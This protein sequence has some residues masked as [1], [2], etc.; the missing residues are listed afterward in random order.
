MKTKLTLILAAMAALTGVATAAPETTVP[1]A[2]SVGR[3]NCDLMA[4]NTVRAVFH[5]IQQA[6]PQGTVQVAVFEVVQNLAHKRV[7]RYGDGQM[8]AG[9]I[10]TVTMDRYLPGQPSSVVDEIMQMQPG[11]EAVMKIDH[12]F[13]FEEPQG[14]NIRPCTRLARKP[15][16]APVPGSVPSVLPQQ[17]GVPQQV[18]P[19]VP[20]VPGNA[21]TPVIPATPTTPATPATP[22]TPGVP[23]P[24]MPAVPEGNMGSGFLYGT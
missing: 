19:A 1:A 7:V 13:L 10:F 6:D 5:G 20:T 24:V 18:I 16:T 17:P 8:P 2:P 21:T 22:G 9:M 12:L 14:Q 4:S 15:A 23:T 3:G 11:E